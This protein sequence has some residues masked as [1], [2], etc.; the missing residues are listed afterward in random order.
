MSTLDAGKLCVFST[1]S[2][3]PSWSLTNP[4]LRPSSSALCWNIKRSGYR[5]DLGQLPQQL[6]GYGDGN[7]NI[8]CWGHEAV[9]GSPRTD[10]MDSLIVRSFGNHVSGF[11]YRNLSW[12]LPSRGFQS[13][14]RA[15]THPRE[16]G[17]QV[18][19]GEWNRGSAAHGQQKGQGSELS[20]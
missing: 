11:M 6:A 5:S 12:I 1:P 13:S 9:S 7:K 17:Y 8:Q 19:S 10:V 4:A 18:E 20:E 14:E 2:H 16:L 3:H 15:E